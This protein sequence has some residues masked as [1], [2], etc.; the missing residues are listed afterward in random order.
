METTN[1]MNERGKKRFKWELE[2][3]VATRLRPFPGFPYRDE[4]IW[5]EESFPT[6]ETRIQIMD[7]YWMQYKY[8]YQNGRENLI[9]FSQL[10]N[11][12]ICHEMFW[13][14]FRG[15]SKMFIQI[16][17]LWLDDDFSDKPD[18]IA[19]ENKTITLSCS[20]LTLQMLDYD[21][22]M[23]RAMGE[24][25][26]EEY[27]TTAQRYYRPYIFSYVV[28]INQK[29]YNILKKLQKNPLQR[30]KLF[31]HE[32][33]VQA[34]Y[35][36][37]ECTF[38][39]DIEV[40]RIDL[41][42]YVIQSASSIRKIK[43]DIHIIENEKTP[44]STINSI[45]D[46]YTLRNSCLKEDDSFIES[47]EKEL[48]RC[49]L[50]AI[51]VYKIGNGNCVFAQSIDSDVSFFYDIGFNYRH[52]PKK[53]APGVNYSYVDSMREI[54]AKN[55]SFF[56]L[57]HWDMDHIAG[58]VASG[59]NFFDKN[60][61]APDCYDACTDAKRIA[62]FLDLKNHLFLA[63]RRPRKGKLPGRLIGQINIKSDSEP[64]E[65]QSIYRLY[66][67]K[68][69]QC[70][71][72]YPNCEGIVI[73]YMDMI[74]KKRVLMMGDVNYAS[75]NKA[76]SSNKD[77]L[78]AE[79]QIDYLIV[80]HHGSEHTAY[81]QITDPGKGV[82]KGSKAIICCTNERADNRPNDNHRK[83]LEIRFGNNVYTTEE[84][85]SKDNSIKI[86]L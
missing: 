71:S 33:D 37:L 35:V 9:E 23:F 52:K 19:D 64:F 7:T 75:F 36:W 56:I 58:S 26:D 15:R 39:P 42:G 11:H 62:R 81:D 32:G 49:S 72:S 41:K 48:A 83:E 73:E 29:T 54:Y 24:A 85:P 16:K 60:W 66:M 74:N 63:K 25:Q 78:F 28:E 57:S 17:D 45:L 67:G 40:S 61:F 86:I 21:I 59:R 53:I 4:Y 5:F 30:E 8:G 27:R 1:E 31:I 51:D 50:S 6:A 38:N 18:G 44:I 84:I 68:K 46:G 80:P 69:D 3:F 77:T 70:D 43:T 12:E 79:T 55:P 76:R 13:N 2:K 65:I 22:M 14:A 20:L 34:P 47:I 10:T 82:R